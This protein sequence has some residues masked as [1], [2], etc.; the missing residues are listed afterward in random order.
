MSPKEG[1]W[2]ARPLT[3]LLYFAFFGWHNHM[4]NC[5]N[6]G[7]M[8]KNQLLDMF[9]NIAERNVLLEW[10]KEMTVTYM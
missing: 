9:Q 7:N 3:G 5:L 1:S 2:K 6:L 4:M 8:N 10:P